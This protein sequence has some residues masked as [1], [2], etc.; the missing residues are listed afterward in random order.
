MNFKL[1][2]R[3]IA[4]LVLM[5]CGVLLAPIMVALVY[6]ENHLLPSFAIPLGAA[7]VVAGLYL[8]LVKSEA[9][10]LST[11]AGFFLVSMAWLVASLLGAL[12]FVISGT[13]PR[14]VDAFFETMS[15]FTTTG[16]SIL[17]DIE[18]LPRSM[19]FW[20]SLTHWLGGMGIIVLTVAI[21]PILG[22]GGLQLIKAEAPGPTVDKIT[23]KVTETAKILWITYFVLTGLEVLLLMLGG[24]D[25]YDALTH[26]FGTLA[27][28]GF[29]PKAASVG[30][31]DSVFI[32]VVITVFMVLAGINFALYYKLFV[33]RVESVFRD[34][35]VRA[36][37]GIFVIVA[38]VL[39]VVLRV[40]GVYAT[41]GESLRYGSFQ[42]ASILTTTG[43]ATADFAVWPAAAQVLLFLLMFI[44]GSS[45]STGGGMKV[46]RIMTL[47][48]Q[49]VNEMNYL[50]HPR[51]IFSI[52]LS[53][54]QVKKN[55]VYAISGFVILYMFLIL[56][57]T[58]IVGLSGFDLVTSVSTAL[59][60]LGNIGPGFAMVGPTQNYAFFPDH[61]KWV[62]SF[63]MM[64]GRLEVFTVLILFTPRFW[65]R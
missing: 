51:G 37:L 38:A 4:I 50:L 46:V 25:L 19:L 48:K 23:P 8:A 57:T 17:T 30:H 40:N 27:T 13:I 43:Y 55:I 35:E 5:L 2:F 29:S 61:V 60:T 49:A 45:G 18:A 62:L 34:S 65:R 20:R 54:S 24:M 10:S 41:F 53:G 42:A 14:F 52:K 7:A 9:S 21:F 11:R 58:V 12:P 16:A 33:G 22:I 44:G 56:L 6:G 28:G 31:Y 39:A 36:Y 15:G 64:M 59:V 26:T 1:V 47:L 63:V 32:D 3:I